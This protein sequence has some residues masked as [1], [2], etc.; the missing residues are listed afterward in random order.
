MAL[1]FSPVPPARALVSSMV[2]S[3]IKLP[4]W[5]FTLCQTRMPPLPEPRM[6]FAVMTRPLLSL[7]NS[8][9]SAAPVMVLP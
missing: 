3:A 6:V 4:S 9:L 7:Q 1:P 2:L 8:A 5:R